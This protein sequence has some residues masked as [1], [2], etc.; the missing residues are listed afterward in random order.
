[1]CAVLCPPSFTTDIYF[2]AHARH[3]I[4]CLDDDSFTLLLQF[5]PYV[6]VLFYSLERFHNV[7]I[8]I[9]KSSEKGWQ[10][11]IPLR[12][13]TMDI[14]GY[15]GDRIMIKL[16]ISYFCKLMKLRY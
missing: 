5:T 15:K 8:I 14:Q 12:V 11:L 16:N 6:K 10:L 3:E 13:T 7:I 2:E 1:M 9:N 4:C